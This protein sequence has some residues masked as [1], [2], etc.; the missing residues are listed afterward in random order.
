MVDCSGVL[1][2][3]FVNQGQMLTLVEYALLLYRSLLPT[4]VWYKFFLNKEYGSLFSSLTTGL[5]LTFKLTSIVEK[6]W[7]WQLL[8]PSCLARRSGIAESQLFGLSFP[9]LQVQSFVASLKAL[10]R[11]E[12]HYGTYATSEQVQCFECM[13]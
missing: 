1:C 12:V 10:S 9:K 5:Y 11:K 6:V 7:Y 13:H 3:S 2:C 8:W 4:P